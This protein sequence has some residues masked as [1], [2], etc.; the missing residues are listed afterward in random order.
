[1]LQYIWLWPMIGPIG[2]GKTWVTSNCHGVGFAAHDQLCFAAMQKRSQLDDFKVS[3]TS[4]M[5]GAVVVHAPQIPRDP[6]EGCS[7]KVSADTPSG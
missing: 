3:A 7:G 6:P 4:D 5:Q 2:D 1:M